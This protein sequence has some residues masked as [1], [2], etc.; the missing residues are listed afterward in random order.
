ME[1][2]QQTPNHLQVFSPTKHHRSVK[3]WQILQLC[4]SSVVLRC[5]FLEKIKLSDT[6]LRCLL[7]SAVTWTTTGSGIRTSSPSPASGSSCTPSRYTDVQQTLLYISFFSQLIV[8]PKLFQGNEHRLWSAHLCVVDVNDVNVSFYCS[9]V[10]NSCS[11]LPIPSLV[12]SCRQ[13]PAGET[14]FCVC[15]C[16]ACY[17]HFQPDFAH[18]CKISRLQNVSISEIRDHVAAVMLTLF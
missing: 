16:V 1:V 17:T 10:K 11:C 13:S 9:K 2:N 7:T 3:N 18:F 4:L 14:Y 5:V 6:N 12:W 8:P 15:V